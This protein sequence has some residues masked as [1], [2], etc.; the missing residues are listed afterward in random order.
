MGYRVLDRYPRRPHLEFYRG[1]PNPFYGVS[2][3][4][5]A[6]RV[7]ERARALD[8]ST[9]AALIWTFHRALIGIDAFRTRLLGEDVVL[10]DTLQIGIAL[11]APDRTFTFAPLDWDPEPPRFLAHAAG[12]MERAKTHVDLSGEDTPNYAY[13]TALPKVPFTSF[14]HVALPDPLQGQPEI[15][16]GRFREG[17]G[18]SIVPVGV[19]VNHVYVDG[20]DLGDLYESLTE[21]F[22]NAF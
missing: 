11:P 18:R 20:A 12:R 15:A 10:F 22:A 3:D 17:D 8:A 21:S 4:L 6:T 13:Y 1:N 14:T 9:Y 5:D 16:F 19:L 7:R 2:F